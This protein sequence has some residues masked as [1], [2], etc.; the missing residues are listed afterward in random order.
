MVSIIDVSGAQTMA[1]VLTYSIVPVS[2]VRLWSLY[3]YTARELPKSDIIQVG[4]QLT[5]LHISI[6]SSNQ[7]PARPHNLHQIAVEKVK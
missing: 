1:Y 4:L 3:W 7:F 2:P 6:P 5:I